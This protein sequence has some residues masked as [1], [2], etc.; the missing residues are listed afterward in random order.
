MGNYLDEIVGLEVVETKEL[1]GGGF[2][3]LFDDGII[4]T[5]TNDENHTWTRGLGWESTWDSLS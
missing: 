2:A 5:V 1:E 3:I 4:L